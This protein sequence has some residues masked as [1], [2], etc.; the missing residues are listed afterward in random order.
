MPFGAAQDSYLRMF[1]GVLVPH[2]SNV[3]LPYFSA[4]GSAELPFGIVLKQGTGAQ[5]ALKPT[6]TSDRL[7]GILAHEHAYSKEVQLGTVGVKP[8]QPLNVVQY[9]PLGMYVTVEE[10]VTP[11]SPVRVRVTTAAAGAIRTSAVA[12]GTLNISSFARFLD[13]AAAG[14]TVRLQFNFLDAAAAVA[15]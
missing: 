4:E 11:T 2:F 5:D 1:A 9:A 13:S 3:V 14:E 7:I 12:G 8:T 15:D 10:A 6:A